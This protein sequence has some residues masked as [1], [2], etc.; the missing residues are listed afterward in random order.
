MFAVHRH[1]PV[2][3]RT[4]LKHPQKWAI[5]AWIWND[6]DC[7]TITCSRLKLFWSLV[8]LTLLY[9]P[10]RSYKLG[11]KWK[12]NCFYW[13][14]CL[15]SQVFFLKNLTDWNIVFTVLLSHNN[16]FVT[17]ASIVIGDKKIW[18]IEILS[19]LCCCHTITRSWLK[20]L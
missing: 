13:R 10:W 18:P 15:E 17:E 7:R 11:L 4:K 19:L 9:S 3:R 2:L 5:E 16:S 14:S 20:L 6:A 1:S 12:K 8:M